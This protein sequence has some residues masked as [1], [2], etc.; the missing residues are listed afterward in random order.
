MKV[1]HVET[2]AVYKNVP[3]L[4]RGMQLTVQLHCA[5]KQVDFKFISAQ[6]RCIVLTGA[7]HE[8]AS[9]YTFL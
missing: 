1:N 6:I 5:K 8:L 3:F 4:D 7:Q 9:F 2:V